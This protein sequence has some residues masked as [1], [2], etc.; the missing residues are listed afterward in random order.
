[1]RKRVSAAVPRATENGAPPQ[2]RNM[3]DLAYQM[4]LIHP[5]VDLQGGAVSQFINRYRH[6]AEWDY[7]HPIEKRALERGY[8]IIIWQEQVVRLITDVSGMS[9]R[10]PTSCVARSHAKTARR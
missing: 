7:D 6:G 2:T 9:A 4:A 10:T 3:L 8:G 5:G 1:M